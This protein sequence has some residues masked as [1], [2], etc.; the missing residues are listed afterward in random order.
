LDGFYVDSITGGNC[1]LGNFVDASYR[2]YLMFMNEDYVSSRTFT[3]T[4]DATHVAGLGRVDKT[5]GKLVLAY[6]RPPS[7]YTMSLPLSAG[8][9][10]LFKVLLDTNAPTVPANLQ[11]VAESPTTVRLTWNAASDPQS[12]IAHYCLYRDNVEVGT[13]TSLA[14]TNIGLLPATSYSYK[15]AAVNGEGLE[16]GQ[17]SPI[18]VSTAAVERPKITRITA[19]NGQV[20]VTWSSVIGANY[21]LLKTPDLGDTNWTSVGSPTNATGTEVSAG[22]LLGVGSTLYRVRVLP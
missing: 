19:T 22:E 10:E 7:N 20:T 5:T 11:G 8:N 1:V 14:F 2:T 15:V 3:I 13:S 18:S 17:S 6:V 9:G 12:G 21:Q 4:L 16:S